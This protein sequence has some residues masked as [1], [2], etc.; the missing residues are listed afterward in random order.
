MLV[1]AQFIR[2]LIIPLPQKAGCFANRNTR[3]KPRLS[4]VSLVILSYF[5]SKLEKSLSCGAISHR[6]NVFFRLSLKTFASPYWLR[7]M[8]LVRFSLLGVLR[9]VKSVFAFPKIFRFD[10]DSFIKLLST[11]PKICFPQVWCDFTSTGHAITCAEL[12]SIN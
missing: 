3:L 8:S 11:K 2:I 4:R 1:A 10:P 5:E 6:N 7:I 12:E 9:G